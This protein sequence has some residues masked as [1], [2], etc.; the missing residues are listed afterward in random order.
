[1]AI[2]TLNKKEIKRITGNLNDEKLDDVLSLV[3]LGVESITEEIIDAEVTPNRPDMLSQSGILRALESYFGKKTGLKHYKLNKPAKNFMVKIDKSVKDIRPYTACAIVKNLKF[4]DEKIK[5]V[6]DIQEKLHSTLGRDRKK[7]AIGIYPLEKISLPIKFEARK[8][9]EIKFV[10]LEF[11]KELNGLQILQQHPAGRE[12]AHLLEHAEKF[13]VFVDSKGEILSMPPIINSHKTGKITQET[14]EVFIECSGF[15]L[16]VLKKTLNIIVTMLADIGG[17]I[18]QMK[19]DYGKLE[20]TPN[21]TPEKMKLG[22]ENVNKLL[23]LSLKDAEMK[24]LL[25]KMGY[26]YNNKQAEIPAY[27]TD[28]LH[29]VDL[30]EDI[31]IAYGYE[32]FIPEIPKIATI[33]EE[34][35]RE[36]FKRKIAEIL[37]GLSLSELSTLHLLTREDLERAKIKQAIEVEES[38]TDYKFLRPNLLISALK[39]LAENVDTEYPQRVFETGRIFRL[40][41]KEETGVGEKEN[42]IIALTP[43]NFTDIKQVLEYLGRMLNRSFTLE[44]A[45]NQH[46]IEG[47]TGKIMYNEKEIGVIGE[48]HPQTLKNWHLKM[49]VACFELGLDELLS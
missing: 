24:K 6:I 39:I 42:L 5:E 16:N 26:N 19:L 27:R 29:P 49:P 17:S 23:G 1:M 21:L 12:Y 20:I 40:D 25:G 14:K 9:E 46:F 35:K 32:N 36:L 31:A 47:R 22:L 8:P 4:N 11:D 45:E 33:G 41:E 37:T 3:G 34:D 43:S 28:I 13:P 15:D 10:P 18:Y 7:F 44:E 48:I 30:I 2:V 38:K